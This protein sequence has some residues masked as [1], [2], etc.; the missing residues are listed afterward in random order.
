MMPKRFITFHDNSQSLNPQ[1]AQQPPSFHPQ[2]QSVDSNHK[3]TGYDGRVDDALRRSL[4]V[5]RYQS[6]KAKIS[7]HDYAAHGGSCRDEERA[8]GAA[9][10][11]PAEAA[12][13]Y[14]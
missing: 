4:K 8:G 12:T 13:V 9:D 7:Y 2:T 10:G 14:A 3:T 1:R 6:S 5:T 11:A